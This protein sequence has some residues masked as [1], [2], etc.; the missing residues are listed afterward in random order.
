[1]GKK[2]KA[3]KVAITFRAPVEEDDLLTEYAERTGRTKTDVLR[4]LMRS[5]KKRK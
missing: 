1:M 4:E 5:L 3:S 2:D